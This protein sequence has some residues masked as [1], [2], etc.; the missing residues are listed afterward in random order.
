MRKQLSWVGAGVAAAL[1]AAG[2]AVAHGGGGAKSVA[3]VA[4]T[5]T[6]TQ[7][8]HARTTTCTN[9]DGTWQRVDA[10]YTGTASGDAPLAGA[11]RL[12]VRAVVNT[13]KDLGV[14]T[15]TL[16]AGDTKARLTAVYAGGKLTGLAQGGAGHGRGSLIA[17]LSASFSPTG[18]FTNGKLGAAD[19]G[20]AI[21][22]VPGRCDPQPTGSAK[23]VVRGTV[24][25][26]SSS[27]LVIKSGSDQI[28]CSVDSRLAAAVAKLAAGSTVHATCTLANGSYRLEKV[29]R[30]R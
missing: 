26:T 13:T 25:S 3:S 15:G 18:G 30:H 7:V 21:A 6:A 9:A 11:A 20:A 28:A 16:R 8:T 10:T 5:F 19:G 1:I 23:L 22:L 12:D 27:S 2:A 24:V 14:V 4:S 29:D 17:N